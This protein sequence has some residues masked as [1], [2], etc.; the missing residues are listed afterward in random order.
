MDIKLRI[1]TEVAD[2]EGT[3]IERSQTDQSM[4]VSQSLDIARY[5]P[6]NNQSFVLDILIP[7]VFQFLLFIPRII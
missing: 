7:L 3:D 5:P 2:S 1:S 6:P 4:D